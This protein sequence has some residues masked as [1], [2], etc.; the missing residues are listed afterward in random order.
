MT[1][2]N[3]PLPSDYDDLTASGQRQARVDAVCNQSTPDDLVWAWSFF[4]NHYLMSLPAGVWHKPP[5]YESPQCHYQFIWDI[6]AYPRNVKI[7]PRSFAKSTLLEE[8]ILTLCYGRAPFKVLLIKSGD[9]FI[10]ESFTRLMFQIEDNARLQDDFGRLKPRKNQAGIWSKSRLWLNNG[11][12]LAGRSVMGKLLGIRPQLVLCD[13]VEFDPTMRVA[14][15]LL[16]E[17]FRRMWFN[18]VIPMLD[19]GCA[20]ALVGTLFSRKLF[21]YRMATTPTE[22]DP[23]LAYWNREVLAIVDP[24]TGTPIWPAKFPP[25]KIEELRKS[26]PPAVFAAQYM[27]DPGTEEDKVF[28]L[29]DPFGYY[30]V[31][32]ADTDYLDAPLRS[33]AVLVSWSPHADTQE[34]VRV[35][36]PFGDTISRCYRLI[37]ADPIRKPS[38]TSDFACVMAIAVE[39]TKHFQDVWWLL[40]IRLGRPKSTVFLDWIWELGCRWLPRIVA[41]ESIG[42]QKDIADQ[43]VQ[44]YSERFSAQDWSPRV[45]PL[46]YRRDF[47]GDLGKGTRISSLA[48]RFD[49]NKIKY[50][51]H[52]M[53]KP[54]WRELKQQIDDFTPD[55]NLLPFDDAI[56]TLAMTNFVVKPRGLRAPP[57]A[58]PLTLQELLAKGE[59]FIPGTKMPILSVVNA[60]E[61]TPDALAGIDE[62]HHRRRTKQDQKRRASRKPRRRQGVIHYGNPA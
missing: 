12:Q 42:L 57:D 35:E 20:A 28:T 59:E 51:K 9:D 36:R 53:L 2:P 46:N 44:M 8:L 34:P 56:D 11:F 29:H 24:E 47:S 38:S 1:H 41:V 61:L 54:G 5:I 58:A 7:M 22:E 32:D 6:G 60:D 62:M 50:P 19:A 10:R 15:A 52:L 27:N 48:R 40:D 21:I 14:P 55:L 45:L 16:S 33:K 13:D 31:K 37:V 25:E 39:R 3:Y 30:T 17:N 49:Y 18:S 26:M 4:R 23:L 43:A